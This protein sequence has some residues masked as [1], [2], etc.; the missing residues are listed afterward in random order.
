MI[1]S[2]SIRYEN[3]D[4]RGE[5]LAKTFHQNTRKIFQDF[6]MFVSFI[7]EYYYIFKNGYFS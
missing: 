2:I 6:L 3:C 1:V 7:V 4:F 5:T